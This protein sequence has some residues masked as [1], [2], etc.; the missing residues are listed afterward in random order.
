VTTAAAVLRSVGAVGAD[1]GER[2]LALLLAV[3]ALEE[4]GGEP[5]AA[6]LVR[7]DAKMCRDRVNVLA[8]HSRCDAFAATKKAFARFMSFSRF[9]A[10][11]WSVQL[12]HK[13]I[14]MNL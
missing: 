10:S 14:L 13:R 7:E 2:R 1:I 9:S 8:F 11:I 4:L 6:L 12:R 5:R 3:E